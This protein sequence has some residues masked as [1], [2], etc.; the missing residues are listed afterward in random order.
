MSQVRFIDLIVILLYFLGVS[1]AGIYFARRNKST[2]EY[3]LGNRSFPGW[4]IGI[5]ML[6][7]GISSISFVAYPGDAYKT[8]WLRMVPN[9]TYP[10]GMLFAAY[11]FLPFFRRGKITSAFEYLE[12]RYGPSTRVYGAC[13]YVVAQSLRISLIL[14]LV[15]L[16]VHEFTH[17]PAWICVIAAGLVVSFYTV[18]GG[19]EAVVWT[20]V[21]QTIILIG[22]SILCLIVIV[23]KLPGGLGQIVS[24]GVAAG[25]F[26]FSEFNAN[27]QTLV[28]PSWDFSFLRKTATMML[29]IG[30]FDWLTENSSDQNMIQR[31]CASKSPAD[32]RRAIWICCWST[33]PVWAYFMF[34]GTALWV[35]FRAFPNEAAAR[36][37]NG[38]ARAEQILP[39]F[40]L[41]YMPA[42][43]AGLVVA[44]VLA[45]A[46]SSL[47]SSI[48]AI[49]TVSVVDLY[50]RHLVK[51]RSDAHYLAVARWIAIAASAVMIGGALLLTASKDVKTFRD[52]MTVLA[53]LAGGGLLGIYMM[54]FFTKLGDARC[55]AAGIV[56]TLTFTLYRGLTEFGFMPGQF[57]IAWLD[58]V[59][60]YYTGILGNALMFGIG[61]GLALLLPSRKRDLTNLTV[62]T[63]DGSP[64]E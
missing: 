56:C 10:I 46:M 43:I 35:F 40:I 33:L 15:S 52:T 63:Q 47:D 5:S 45:A 38:E 53:A 39:F 19:F 30:L 51:N 60:A 48:N 58:A 12:K 21:V 20:D 26:G 59:D 64:L 11:V 42:G 36:M 22:G 62:W 57:R 14:Y 61:F 7:T 32:A 6:G 8:A 16:L 9:F 1:A 18:A 27:T 54:G 37:L 34:L 24:E 29:I 17:W 25:K 49:C 23:I 2:E 13:A 31:Y 55:I 41:N 4:A 44:A 3:F 28:T 50:R